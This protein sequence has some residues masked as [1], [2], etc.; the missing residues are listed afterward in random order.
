M[1]LFCYCFAPQK[2]NKEMATSERAEERECCYHST[3]IFVIPYI[4]LRDDTFE[5]PVFTRW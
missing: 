4:V 3:I 5:T 1:F 2:P